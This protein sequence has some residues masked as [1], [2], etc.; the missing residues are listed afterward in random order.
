MTPGRHTGAP[1]PA[2]AGLRGSPVRLVEVYDVALLDLDGVVYVGEQAVPHAAQALGQARG[3]GQRLAFVTNNALR[4]PSAV[5]EQLRR[6]GVSATAEDVVTSAQAAARV[7]RE[8]LPAEGRVLVAGG[9][10][11]RLALAEVGLRPVADADEAPRAVVTGHDPEQT[12]RRLA[13]AALALAA[14]LPWVAS[15]T[16]SS[17]PSARGA[18]PGAGA[19]VALLATATGRQPD[20]VAGKPHPALHQESVER[21]Q[22]RHPLVVGDRLDT[23]IEGATTAGVDSLLVLTGVTGPGELLAAPPGRRPSYLAEDLRGL[24]VPHPSPRRTAERVQAGEAVARVRSGVVSV[25]G[26]D[27]L[28][29]LRA[30]CV[31][32]W[33]ASDMGQAARDVEGL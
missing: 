30:A 33:Q 13:E 12:W 7:L 1:Q 4:P 27:R 14:G 18:L 25:A 15:N 5:A 21:T 16:D 2:A 8:R 28:D 20:A 26:P 6:L 32:A 23:D 31:C 29:R 24:L 17:I 10:G 9:E 19:V 3:A 22:A 11:L